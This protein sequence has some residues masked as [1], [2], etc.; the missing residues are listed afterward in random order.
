[1]NL[2][3]LRERS[4]LLQALSN[5]EVGLFESAATELRV[6]AGDI[7]FEEEGPA[8]V[9]YIVVKGKIGLELTSPGK[10]PI[11][12]QTLGPGDLVGVS[13]LFPPHRW[14]WRAR[15]MVDSELA[16]FDATTI[17]SEM[18]QNRDLAWEVLSVVSAEVVD[19]LHRTRVQLLDLY[20]GGSR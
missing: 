11:V 17:R 1:M 14:N 12:I 16:V 20:R 6:S 13:W 10:E 15:A 19:R 5:T 8:D 18:E 2:A 3:E 4:A 7:L 9:F